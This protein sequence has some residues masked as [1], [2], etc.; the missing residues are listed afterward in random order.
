MASENILA[1]LNYGGE[2]FGYKNSLLPDVSPFCLPVNIIDC[3]L[4][5]LEVQNQ[6]DVTKPLEN[7]SYNYLFI[8]MKDQRTLRMILML[9]LKSGYYAVCYWSHS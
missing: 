3:L 2:Y 7:V 4:E 1:V 8:I 5:E 6:N 9:Y